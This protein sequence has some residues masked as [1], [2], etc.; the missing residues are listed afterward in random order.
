MT[1]DPYNYNIGGHPRYLVHE[2]YMKC[3]P[4]IL[5]E[6]L[7]RMARNQVHLSM[8]TRKAGLQRKIK[9]TIAIYVDVVMAS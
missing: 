5:K 4:A 3:L 6:G 7:N 8:Q 9:P 1:F 2:T